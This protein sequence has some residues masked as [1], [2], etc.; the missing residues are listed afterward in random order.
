MTDDAELLQRYVAG[1]S[2]EAFAELVHRHLNLVYS[3]ALRRVGGDAHLAQDATQNVFIDLARKAP[4][5]MGRP[6]LSG[7]LHRSARYAAGNLVRGERRRRVREQ[8]TYLMQDQATTMEGVTAWERLRPLLDETLGE[9]SEADRDAVALRFFEGKAF[10]DVGRVLKLTE[11][12]ARKR[13]ERAVDKLTS[14]LARRGVTSTSAAVATALAGQGLIAAPAG[15]ATTVAGSALAAAAAGG[16][17]AA[18]VTL[19]TA[20]AS[21]KVL[22][23]AAV[24]AGAVGVA[25]Y[26]AGRADKQASELAVVSRERG[27][28]QARLAE[29][30]RRL[31]TAEQRAIDAEQDNALLL[32]A[33]Q[34]DRE[35]RSVAA[36]PAS[37][38][39]P[40]GVEVTE[41]LVRER[42]ARGQRLARDGDPAEALRELLWCFDEG[43]IRV[44]SFT[45]VR[46]SFLLGEIARL[47]RRHPPALAALRERRDR[48]EQQILSGMP[49]FLVAT[50]F[51]AINRTLKET[52]RTLALLDQLPAGDRRR[53]TLA[54]TAFDELVDARRY[55]DA[56]SGRPFAF[57]RSSLERAKD[58]PQSLASLP[59]AEAVRKSRR[60]HAITSTAKH[61]EV[62]AGSGRL[63]D[64]RTLANQ[65]LAYDASATTRD[66]IENHA[67][68]AGHPNLLGGR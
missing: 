51:G 8:E 9:L 23:G 50:N 47:G 2:Q 34:S 42:Y 53:S 18:G 49:D 63:D 59:N 13:V 29:F 41:S 52:D 55:E 30:D 48:A 56:L 4:Q 10:A 46:A 3:V 26:E 1:H 57:M 45:G 32:S 20:L 64:A 24:V 54:G 36:L 22:V 11:D 65:L 62:L 61:I 6:V 12:T 17:V 21:A 37:A 35:A 67:A 58:E 68:R 25:T 7:W 38:S 19:W 66:V 60:E 28:L 43:M 14:I 33:V 44:S 5:L 15:L 16:G 27:A 40:A 39:S 31:R